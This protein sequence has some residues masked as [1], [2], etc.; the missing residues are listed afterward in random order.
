M[1]LIAQPFRHPDS[2]IYYLRR[3]V[4]DDLRQIIGK[5]EIRRSL[6]TRN[7]QQAKAAFAL[8]YAESERLFKDARQGLYT[9][10][11][12]PEAVARALP[13]P[14][15]PA[16]TEGHIKLSE[17]LVRYVQSIS[18]SGRSEYV[19]R[20]HAV[21]YSR[22]V[23]RYITDMGD[24]P[25][26]AIQASDIHV[27]AANLI[28]PADA[29][30]KPLATSSTRL[31][32][33]RLS[34]VLAFSVDS[35]LIETN[36]VTASRIHKRLGSGKPKRRLDDNRGY[37]WS[38]LVTLF[39][40]AEFQQLRTAEGRPGNAVFWIPL[41]AAYTGGRREE[42]A[43]LY[44][45][46]IHQ[47][48]GGSWFIRIIDDRPDK[49]VKTDSSRRQIPVHP[50]LIDL[51]LLTLLQGHEPGTR[52]FPQLV[53]VSDGFA[54]IVSKSWRPITQ[55]CGVYQP[56]RNPLHAFRH[57]FKT[58]AREHGI[59]K[60]VSDWITGHASGHIGDSYG[61]N[62]LSRMATEIQKLPSIAKA[63][64]LLPRG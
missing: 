48:E 28:Q 61:I 44:V 31:L 24:K 58:L 10:H 42:L 53:K 23:N 14:V 26:A 43:Q 50:D 21:D 25:I 5:T 40:H 12:K 46:D 35:G 63:A 34:S 62:P 20:R 1:A 9:E 39:S 18:M 17:A 37:S 51:G 49:S 47:H 56:G 64:G 11:Y 30:V 52:L 4:P 55:K 45:E 38:E 33:A 32:L 6:R 22:A 57:S 27:F 60:E 54:G 2:G 36:P 29:N 41:I 19:S 16:R 8:A 15:M 13:T 3:R 59:P 7:H